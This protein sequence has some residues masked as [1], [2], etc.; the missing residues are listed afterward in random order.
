MYGLPGSFLKSPVMLL[1]R[2]AQKRK[3]KEKTREFQKR[4]K[5]KFKSKNSIMKNTFEVH[6][7]CLFFSYFFIKKV[8]KQKK[9]DYVN[10]IKNVIKIKHNNPRWCLYIS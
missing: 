7:L 3:L 9:K 5:I 8:N 10:Q 1:Q 4:K 6:C 2:T